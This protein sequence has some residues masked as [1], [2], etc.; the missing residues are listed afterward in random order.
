MKLTLHGTFV[1]PALLSIG[2]PLGSAAIVIS[3]DS[4][5]SPVHEARRPGTEDAGLS[6]GVN[7]LIYQTGPATAG[8]VEWTQGAGGFVQAGVNLEI[9]AL[10]PL[11]PA[12]PLANVDV[13]LA[14]YSRTDG[15]SL[16]FGREITTREELLCLPVLPDGTVS[17][18]LNDVAGA[19]ILYGWESSS[20]VSGLDILPGVLY[21]VSFTVTSGEGLPVG[22]LSSATFGI[23]TEGVVEEDLSN[24]EILNLL[25]LIS[26]GSDSSSADITYRFTS[27]SPLSSLQFDFAATSGVGVSL[28]GGTE[29]NQDVLTFSNF[30]VTVI[31]EPGV[32][33]MSGVCLLLTCLRRRRIA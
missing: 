2:A 4:F 32:A 12:I 14:A 17:G 22:L 5:F 33:M 3:P 15:S 9:P 24:L 29:E 16:T 7:N 26:I 21:E 8:D 23:P 6:V 18:L 1:L 31:P 11:T 20:V 19:S 28:L 10:P 25:D 27:E 13:Q 30:A